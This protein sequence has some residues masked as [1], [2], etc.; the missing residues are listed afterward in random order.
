M[1]RILIIGV[2]W[3]QVPLVQKAKKK[4]LY[5]IATTQWDAERI[6]ADRIYWADSRDL[7]TLD[8]IIGKEHPDYVIADECD[9][10]MYAVA[11]FAEK[12]QFIGPRLETQVIANNKYLQR[13]CVGM[14]GILQPDYKLCWNFEQALAAADEIGYPVMAKPVDN[15]G[16]I[17]VSRADDAGKLHE[18]WLAAIANSHSRMCLIE[19]CIC[20]TVIA[21]DGFHDS[22]KFEFIAA[23]NEEMYDADSS[24][25]KVLDYPGQFKPGMLERIKQTA[26]R[27]AAAAGISFG[28]THMEFMIEDKTDDLYFIESANRG[29]G[30]FISELVLERITGVDYCSA[31][32]DMAMGRH[33]SVRCGQEYINKVLVYFLSLYGHVPVNE[34]GE[35]PSCSFAAMHVN[36]AGSSTDIKRGASLGRQG[37]LLCEGSS[38]DEMRRAGEEV[39]KKY[40]AT[41]S[42]YLL[43]KEHKD[44][45][46]ED[47]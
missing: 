37:V 41:E 2:G 3:E 35:S 25:T 23:S 28:F 32:L 12:Y 39:E 24:V 18:A 14:A 15:R 46:Q 29:G 36:P 34:F 5:V 8:G 45:R 21:A 16:S 17:G 30:I 10:S 19:K 7:E 27:T 11:Y 4:G 22:E 42:E 38:F 13:E 44:D 47:L 43:I 9:Y 33:V 40:C 20:G 1:K 6:P 31:L 26:E